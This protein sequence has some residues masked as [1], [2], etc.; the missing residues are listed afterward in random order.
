MSKIQSSESR[1]VLLLLLGILSQPVFFWQISIYP[2]DSNLE[3]VFP[4]LTLTCEFSHTFYCTDSILAFIVATF[5][6]YGNHIGIICI[7]QG[8][9]VL[10]HLNLI[11][12]TADALFQFFKLS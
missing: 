10:V 1:H 3:T 7:L 8:C 4:V 2:L 6:N 5:T 11:T 12:S 9:T